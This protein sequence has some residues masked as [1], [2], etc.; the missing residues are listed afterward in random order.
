MS[1]L[2]IRRR[3]DPHRRRHRPTDARR[4]RE[5][6]WHV[7]TRAAASSRYPTDTLYGLAVDPRNDA[8]VERLFALKGR[9]ERAALP[10]IA[11]D[12]DAG[13]RRCADRFGAAE[14]RLAARVLAGAADD[15]RAGARSVLARRLLGGGDDRRRARAR[16]IRSRA[17]SPAAFGVL[18]H[19]DQR[20]SVGRAAGRD[21]RRSRARARR[22]RRRSCSTPGRRPAARRRRSSRSPT[23][24][25]R[26]SAPGAVAWDRVLE[27]LAVMR[28]LASRRARRA[29]TSSERARGARRSLQ[30]SVPPA[31]IP[32]IRSTSSP[33]SPR[34]AG[35]DVVLRVLQ[36]RPRPDPATFLGSGKV[37]TLA[38]ACDEARRRRRHLRQRADARRSC[39]TSRS[40]LDRKVARSH[41]AHPRHLRAARAH[42]GRQAAGRARAAEVPAAAAGRVERRAVAARRRHRHAR[43]RRNEARNRSPAH[44]PS[45]QHRS[46][47]RSTTVRRRRAQLRERRHKAAVPTVAL[48]GYTNAGKTT[49]FNSLT[50]DDA[51]ASDA[52]FVT[53]DPLVRQGAAAGSAAS[54]CVSDTVGFIDRL[55]HSLVAA[56][57]ATLE[58]VAGADLLLHVDRR[59]ESRIASG[60]WRRCVACSPR[61]APSACRRSRSSTSA[62]GS[63]TGSAARLR[64]LY[65]GRAVRLGADRRGPRRA[66]RRD[67]DAARARH[68]SASGSSSTRT[69][70]RIAQRIARALSRR[71]HPAARDRPTGAIS[72]E[73]ECRAA[74]LAAVPT[75]CRA[76]TRVMRA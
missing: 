47:R 13:A 11:A 68:R 53:L 57:R 50:G 15:R 29:R 2:A 35:A 45:H 60:R 72:I 43:P 31:S 5:A 65:P 21:G 62:I 51:V 55:P 14:R 26:S 33:A 20:E 38:A 63:T 41:A 34:A 4:S 6:R 70:T 19:R 9:T 28:T 56:F 64:A 10:L 44:P 71:A 75:T 61:S 12:V 48:V 25:P 7:L 58:E 49:L 66:D 54:C 17:R 74:L 73:A 37:E 16:R 46:R 69:T 76:L 32:N 18:H 1:R 3:C 23:R 30:R 40:A 52:L 27:S 24:R 67:G 42:A 39:A 59:V 36:E 22:R 8:A